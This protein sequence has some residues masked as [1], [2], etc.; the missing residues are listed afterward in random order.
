MNRKTDFTTNADSVKTA[1]DL[2][3]TTNDVVFKYIFGNEKNKDATAKLLSAILELKIQ[4]ADISF[5]DPHLKREFP[6]DKLGVLDM[7]VR[8]PNGKT[9][10]VEMLTGKF[11]NIFR[12]LE[13][14]ISKITVAQ[15]GK[16]SK[17]PEV[18]PVVFILITTEPVLKNTDKYHSEFVMMEKSEHYVLHDLRALHII[19]LSKLPLR[20]RGRL[21]AW[22]KLMLT[23]K[24]EDLMALVKKHRYLESAGD[25]IVEL[26]ES[27]VKAFNAFFN[28]EIK[29]DE[30]VSYAERKKAKRA[31]SAERRKAEET[32]STERRKAEE[33]LSAERR[34]VRDA[35]KKAE[36]MLALLIK[37]GYSAD[38]VEKMIRKKG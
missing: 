26:E 3:P 10:A 9:V 24:K 15:L 6:E 8:L 17:Y 38:Q 18:Q 34:K 37:Q 30:L 11:S 36:K 31:L 7:F 4:E 14:Y 12:R 1:T 20:S 29:M 28:N 32:L 25:K 19:E 33:T 22:M 16:G 21:A 35:Q 23:D 2:L 13:Y 27:T 5:G